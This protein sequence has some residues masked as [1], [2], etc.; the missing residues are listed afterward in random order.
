MGQRSEVKRNVCA[1]VLLVLS[2]LAGSHAP[3]LTDNAVLLAGRHFLSTPPTAEAG[4]QLS[5]QQDQPGESAADEQLVSVIVKLDRS[6]L[7]AFETAV[8]EQIPDARI[9]YRYNVILGGVALLVP[10]NQV[11]RLATLPGVN[12]VY[13]DTPQPANTNR[14][15]QFIHADN[16]WKLAGGPSN[17]GEGVIVGVID[18]GVYPEHPSLADPDP[19]GQPY[20]VPP[21]KWT[22]ICEQPNDDSPPITCNNKLIGVRAFLETYKAQIGLQPGEPDSARDVAGHGTHVASTAAGNFGVPASLFG[23]S[24]GKISGIAPRAHVAIYRTGGAT[25]SSG[26][27][28]SSD[29]IAAIQQA[30]DDG[31]DI[32]NYSVSGHANAYTDPVSLA[33]LDAYEAGIFV[34]VS[35]SQDNQNLELIGHAAPWVTTVNAT[36]LNRQFHSDVN[37]RAA[38]GAKSKLQGAAVTAGLATPA[39]VTEAAE[40]GDEF[41]GNST[42]DGAFSGLIVVCKRGGQIQRTD[43]SKNVAARGAVGMLLINTQE[44]TDTIDE[45]HAVPAVHLDQKAGEKLLAFLAAHPDTTATFSPSVS[46]KGKGDVLRVAAIGGATQT[47]GVSKP[48]LS[49]PGASIIAAMTPEAIVES[50]FAGQLF[51]AQSGTSMASPHVAG[52]ATLLKALQPE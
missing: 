41:C 10:R 18:S 16:L 11:D 20:P 39:P 13:P 32:I 8:R 34:A 6:A 23:K 5:S 3:V 45:T 1:V 30:V 52:A 43:K 22:G 14:S 2:M 25:S 35:A 4:A 38:D 7:E 33:F 51:A 19:S 31:V 12:A 36:T 21:A 50:T 28:F 46:G 29:V 17:A 26:I 48:D 9:T 49:A 40:A 47:L 44:F 24:Q 15:P 27:H 42:P 37:L